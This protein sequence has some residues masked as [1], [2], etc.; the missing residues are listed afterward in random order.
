MKFQALSSADGLIIHVY[1]PEQRCRHNMTIFRHYKVENRLR[2]VFVLDDV[3][4]CIYGP[5]A[6]F[7]LYFLLGFEGAP[8][9]D[10]QNYFEAFV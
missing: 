3:H 10:G 4:C 2:D 7:R 5:V 6:F 8:L 9:R 1:C